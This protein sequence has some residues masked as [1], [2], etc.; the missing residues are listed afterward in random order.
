VQVYLREA[1]IS[2]STPNCVDCSRSIVHAECSVLHLLDD[3][4]LIERGLR[5]HDER[6]EIEPQQARRIGEQ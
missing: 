1:T 5:R 4:W 6:R 3:G 2:K